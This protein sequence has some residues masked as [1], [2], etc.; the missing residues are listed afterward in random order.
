MT[1]PTNLRA[2]A[3]ALLKSAP[4]F[5]KYHR[6]RAGYRGASQEF[7]DLALGFITA[8]G[9]ALRDLLAA[10]NE[11]V[12]NRT[13]LEPSVKA[14]MRAAMAKL[15]ALPPEA[16]GE[17]RPVAGWRACA[18]RGEKIVAWELRIA[19][20]AKV[21]EWH[22]MTLEVSMLHGGRFTFQIT[23]LDGDSLVKAYPDGGAPFDTL[24]AAQLAAEDAAD[25]LLL[26]GRRALGRV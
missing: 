20:R 1:D 24:D 22:A 13:A 9:D 2:R 11:A 21:Q 14:E 12:D 26:A 5:A 23:D 16:P 10:L 7:H 3:E 8:T 6:E 25:A 4:S 19:P 17:R 18:S 15:A